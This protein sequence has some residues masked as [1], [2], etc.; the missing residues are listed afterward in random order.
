MEYQHMELVAKKVASILAENEATV[1]DL[2]E[3]FNMVRGKLIVT[4]RT[5]EKKRPAY[6][7]STRGPGQIADDGTLAVG[8]GTVYT[9]LTK[10][11]DDGSWKR[12]EEFGQ[13]G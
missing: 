2:P 9:D 1:N 8:P 12:D 5:E 6:L 3:I 11:S 4:V 7:H 13:G 10:P